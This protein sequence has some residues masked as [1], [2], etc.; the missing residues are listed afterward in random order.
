MEEDPR[1]GR[2]SANTRQTYLRCG[3]AFVRHYGKGPMRMGRAEEIERLLAELPSL[4]HVAIVRAAYGA[5]LRISEAC[6]LWVE[7]IDSQRRVIHV[8]AAEIT[9]SLPR[10]DRTRRTT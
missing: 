7:D 5:G 1:L 4:K 8:H 3:A 6:H 2:L 9:A 10:P